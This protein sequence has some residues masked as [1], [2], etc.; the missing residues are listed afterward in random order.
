MPKLAK[1]DGYTLIELVL[2]I[3]IV[4]ILAASSIPAW[5]DRARN[6]LDVTRRNLVTDLSYAREYAIMKHDHVSAKFN[7][8]T[9]SYSIYLTSTGAALPDPGNPARTLSLNLNGADNTAGVALASASIGGT[10]GLRFNSWGAPC[11]SAGNVVTTLGII[12]FTSGAYTDTVR[13][14]AATGYVR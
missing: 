2:V 5:F 3:A 14:E 6:N 11:D 1:P 12:R 4:G 10:P 8:A 9:N 13:V 7:V